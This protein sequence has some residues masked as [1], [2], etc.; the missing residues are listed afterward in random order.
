MKAMMV[1]VAAQVLMGDKTH[2]VTE[3]DFGDTISAIR[4]MEHIDTENAVIEWSYVCGEP[5]CDVLFRLIR[6]LNRLFYLVIEKQN[7]VAVDAALC[8]EKRIS[9]A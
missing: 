3:V 6:H 7:I 9:Q 5:L 2:S 1:R 8:F 4:A